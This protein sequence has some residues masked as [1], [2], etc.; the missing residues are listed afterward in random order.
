MKSR[1][2]QSLFARL[3]IA[4]A[5]LLTVFVISS[6]AVS[7]QK[8][9]DTKKAKATAKKDDR[10]AA[11]SKKDTRRDK[12]SAKKNDKKADKRASA[13]DNKRD[14]RKE[15]ATAK[16]NKNDKSDKKLSKAE[17]R[18]AAAEARK[19]EAE[20]RAAIE[21]ERR[22]REAA[23]RAAIARALAFERGLRTTTVENIAK[24]QTEGEDLH[25][26]QAA[27]N[28]LG[29]HAGS[30]VVMEAQTGKVLT[31]V[32]QDWAVRSTIRPCSTIKLVTGVAALNEGVIS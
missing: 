19:R 22:R 8:K 30:V 13:R 9:G 28:A 14:S 32:N 10:K 4:L 21:A 31:I 7:A 24:D 18:A 12:A 25:I 2:T 1:F 27:I 23:R 29:N 5:L 6:V 20:R 15:K 26:R 16:N 3:P 11:S 17:K